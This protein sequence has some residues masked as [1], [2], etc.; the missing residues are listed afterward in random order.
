MNNFFKILAKYPTVSLRL[1]FA[2]VFVSISL[3]IL[4]I[5]SVTNGANANTRV[6]FSALTFVY[7][8]YRFVTFWLEYQKAK[9]EE[10]IK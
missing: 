8:S 1:L 3:V 6:I 10:G 9:K 2:L 7:A 5:P 4:Y